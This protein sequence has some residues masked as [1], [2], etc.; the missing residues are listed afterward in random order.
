MN[1]NLA[2]LQRDLPRLQTPLH[3]LAGAKDRT[4]SPEQAF[5]VR[6]LLPHTSVEQLPGLG[7]LAHEERPVEIAARI[8]AIAHKCILLGAKPDA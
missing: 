1:W 4:I 6:R 3:L 7:H 5:D 2:E 8:I